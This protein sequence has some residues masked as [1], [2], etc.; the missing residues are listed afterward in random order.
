MR[1]LLP[2]AFI[3]LLALPCFAEAADAAPKDIRDCYELLRKKDELKTRWSWNGSKWKKLDNQDET[4]LVET[5]APSVTRKRTRLSVRHLGG[6][7]GTPQD[8]VFRLLPGAEG[9]VYVLY[10]RE[11]EFSDGSPDRDLSAIEARTVRTVSDAFLRPFAELLTGQELENDE[12]KGLLARGRDCR[13]KLRWDFNA[14][15]RTAWATLLGAEPPPNSAYGEPPKP[16]C[17]LLAERLGAG[18]VLELRWEPQPG[19]YAKKQLHV[20]EGKPR[21]TLAKGVAP[22]TLGDYLLLLQWTVFKYPVLEQHGRAL[23]FFS[24]EA[25]GY[26]LK[27]RGHVDGANGYAYGHV[28]ARPTVKGKAGDEEERYLQAALFKSKDKGVFV[29]LSGEH[30]SVE[31]MDS[32]LLKVF[33]FDGRDFEEVDVGLKLGL[34][35]ALEPSVRESEAGQAA[36]KANAGCPIA[37]RYQLPRFGTTVQ[38]EFYL[39]TEPG[40]QQ[41]G[42]KGYAVTRRCEKFWKKYRVKSQRALHWD[43]EAAA[44]KSKPA[45]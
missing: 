33:R 39:D 38:W 12:W 31:Q 45:R 30:G 24:G 27:S 3:A 4:S 13:A 35:D 18:R 32:D 22:K 19:R 15:G 20:A 42:D 44:F 36:L 16:E 34:A 6:T 9:R 40:A 2:A 8:E 21:T 1:Y 41:P 17:A 43:R 37:T 29:V 10:E 11:A 26:E 7:V 23:R 28:A 14:S 5:S 25:G